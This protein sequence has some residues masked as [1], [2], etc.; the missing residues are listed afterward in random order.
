M[1]YDKPDL[2]FVVHVGSPPSPVSY[3]Q[4]VGR[5][6]RALDDAVV[7]LLASQTD[8]RIWDH[9]AT[10]TIP[11]DP[12]KMRDLLA[13]LEAAD[14]PQSVIQ[15]EAATRFRRTR[16]ELML[17]QLAVDGVTDRTPPDAGSPPANPGPT[18]PPTTT[19]Y[20]PSVAARP[21]SCAPTSPG[22]PA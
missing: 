18:T 19:A 10:A 22:A 2:G 4:Q 9:F 20:S 11:P 16:I 3:Y 14:E 8:D 1:G 17:K 15:L 13:A 6:G 5:A 12:D 21:T 7:M